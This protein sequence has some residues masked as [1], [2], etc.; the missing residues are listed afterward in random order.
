MQD[1]KEGWV[2]A[3]V[4]EKTIKDTKVFL[5]LKLE[6]GTVCFLCPFVRFF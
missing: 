1:D 6:N 5:S 4:I 3:E 2:G